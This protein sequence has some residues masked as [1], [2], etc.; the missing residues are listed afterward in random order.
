MK[1]AINTWQEDRTSQISLHKRKCDCRQSETN[2]YSRPETVQKTRR[3]T[4][5]N[6][7]EGREEVEKARGEMEKKEIKCYTNKSREQVVKEKYDKKK[8]VRRWKSK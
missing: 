1:T 4:A 5:K 8:K 2:E 3:W 6:L 7:D